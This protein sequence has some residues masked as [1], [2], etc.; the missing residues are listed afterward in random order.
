MSFLIYPLLNQEFGLPLYVCGIGSHRHQ[1]PVVRPEGY[2]VHQILFCTR[3]SGT[4]K[5]HGAQYT[6]E[7]NTF[8]YLPPHLP[9]EYY[10][11][12]S[13]WETCW[14]TF[15][16]ENISATLGKLDLDTYRVLNIA[17]PDMLLALFHRIYTTLKAND[18]DC[19]YICSGF[20]YNFLIELFLCAKN[21]HTGYRYQQNRLIRPILEYLDE[22]YA[23]DITLDQLASL[24]HVTP[25]HLCKVFRECLNMRP[26]EYLARKR[27]QEAKKLLIEKKL[28]ISDVGK[29]VGYKDNSYFCA[30]FK[31]QEMVSPS[32][33]RGSY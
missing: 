19:G 4:L 29:A 16:G 8:F 23:S 30:V 2:G 31:K 7:K 1:C 17:E 28:S 33:F 24:V 27:I 20:L 18:A 5:I 22:H 13:P 3:G 11:D 15:N 10:P 25:Q 26:F 14:I 21:R 32:E 12:S 6:I 9:H